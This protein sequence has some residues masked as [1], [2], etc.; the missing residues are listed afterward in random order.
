MTLAAGDPGIF[1][2]GGAFF[3]PVNEVGIAERLSLNA[4]VDDR[5]G[6]DTW[7]LRDGINAAA[8]GDVGDSRLLQGL[9]AALAN[10]RVPASGGFGAG[11]FTAA[12]LVATMTSQIGSD[13]F[14]AD[15]RL[16]F[17]SSQFN[18]LTQQMLDEGVDTD[19]ELQRLLIIEQ[20]YAANVRLIEAA[21]EMMQ[22]VLRL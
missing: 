1:T 17:A 6:G 8:P 4:A 21:D 9:S 3:D 20:T 14:L 16:S 5:Q 7:R 10:A 12:N 22:T 19:R 11:A 18:E 2:D 13:R 15:Q